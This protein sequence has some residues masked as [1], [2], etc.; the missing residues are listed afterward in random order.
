MKF[1]NN[2]LHNLHFCV[3]YTYGLT[4]TINKKTQRT[5]MNYTFDNDILR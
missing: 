2:N 3:I 4:V 5:I 1:S